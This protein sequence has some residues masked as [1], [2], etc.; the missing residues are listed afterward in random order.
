MKPRTA[1]ARRDAPHNRNSPRRVRR[2]YLESREEVVA[3]ERAAREETV[4]TANGRVARVAAREVASATTSRRAYV[5]VK[6]VA[7]PTMLRVSRHTLSAPL[8]R[9]PLARA[10]VRAVVSVTTSHKESA[11][12][13]AAAS[14]TILVPRLLVKNV[15][16]ANVLLV[17]RELASISPKENASVVRNA[18]SRTTL[19]LST[20]MPH[21]PEVRA[22]VDRRS[23]QAHVVTSLEVIASTET[24]A[25]SRTHPPKQQNKR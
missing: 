11:R 12:A 6:T 8:A 18:V 1:P 22:A 21:R 13:K 4:E 10:R 23:Q 9:A 5:N 14:A 19:S 7:F 17:P 24:P 20:P 16:L 25:A 2:R 15:P 3:R